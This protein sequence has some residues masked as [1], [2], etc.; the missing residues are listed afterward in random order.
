MA[1]D[2]AF[3]IQS[4]LWAVP[5]GEPCER[6]RAEGHEARSVNIRT[7]IRPRAGAEWNRGHA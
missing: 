5:W 2:V 1:L 3:A 7:I 6:K 4:A